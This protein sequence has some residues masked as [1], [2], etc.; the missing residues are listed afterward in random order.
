MPRSESLYICETRDTNSDSGT[1]CRDEYVIKNGM[2][3]ESSDARAQDPSADASSTV[4]VSYLSPM[5]LA[6]PLVEDGSRRSNGWGS[7][8]NPNSNIPPPPTS[9]VHMNALVSR[10]HDQE[11]ELEHPI[12]TAPLREL[13]S[14]ATE[15]MNGGGVRVDEADNADGS[16][17]GISD[18]VGS[19]TGTVVAICNAGAGSSDGFRNGSGSHGGFGG[20]G[21]G[22]GLGTATAT[23]AEDEME[24]EEEVE[25]DEL[26][27][28]DEDEKMGVAPL[29]PAM[30]SNGL[31]GSK[32][33]SSSVAVDEAGEDPYHH[34]DIDIDEDDEQPTIQNSNWGHEVEEG[35][36]ITLEVEKDGATTTTTRE[37][38]NRMASQGQASKFVIQNDGEHREEHGKRK[39]H[40]EEEDDED[41]TTRRSKKYVKTASARPIRTATRHGNAV[42]SAATR[43]YKRTASDNVFLASPS[44]A[45]Y[46]STS[47]HAAFTSASAPPSAG[48]AVPSVSSSTFAA[49]S[50]SA[51]ASASPFVTVTASASFA[52]STSTASTSVASTAATSLAFTA[53]ATFEPNAAATATVTTTKRRQRAAAKKGWKG[54][55]EVDSDEDRVPP[56]EFSPAILPPSER[57]T[58][59]RKRFDW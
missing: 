30:E 21:N 46:R 32:D 19:A 54:W 3:A 2:A 22:S 17:L 57:R 48:F 15:L 52:S 23:G 38:E 56:K 36:V 7:G 11:V 29:G 58:R 8:E 5:G 1:P 33:D 59:S 6:S 34:I 39:R 51:S 42:H 31:R 28:E 35:S 4:G 12:P 20:Y 40:D 14:T 18:C 53:A 37:P 43:R 25:E 50:P 24:V 27:E 41:D 55:V 47:P 10:E 26:E 44:L 49:E 9:V 16:R 13:M 45:A